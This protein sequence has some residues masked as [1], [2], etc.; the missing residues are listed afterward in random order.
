MLGELSD[1]TAGIGLLTVSFLGAVPGF[2]PGLALTVFGLVVLA[3]PLLV[4]GTVGAAIYG[5]IVLLARMAR[6]PWRTR[7]EGTPADPAR[8]TLTLG[9]PSPSTG[10]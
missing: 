6:S 5:T 9:R 1:A 4:L 7:E 3:I 10:P 8:R 2:L